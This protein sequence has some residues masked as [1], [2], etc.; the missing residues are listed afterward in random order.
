MPKQ[1]FCVTGNELSSL[2]LADDALLFSSQSFGSVDEFEQAW[3]KKL[4]MASKFKLNYE[5]IRSVTKED[6]AEKIVIVYGKGIG[7]PSEYEFS[8]TNQEDYAAFYTFLEREQY[9]TKIH[10]T[11]SPFKAISGLLRGLLFTVG[12]TI[13]CYFQADHIPADSGGKY[14]LFPLLI[15]LL[16]GKGLLVVGTGISCY[17]FYKIRKRYNDPPSQTKLVRQQSPGYT[18][19]R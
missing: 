2:V 8:F 10:E 14:R 15:E 1:I 6:Q 9:F 11:L 12:M 16:G 3:N 7:I 17:I 19:S 5:S 18:S 13:F 4:T